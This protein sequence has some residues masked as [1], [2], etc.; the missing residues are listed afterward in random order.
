MIFSVFFKENNFHAKEKR[1]VLRYFVLS[2][3]KKMNLSVCFFCKCVH[4]IRPFDIRIYS[5]NLIIAVEANNKMLTFSLMMCCR[6]CL[7]HDLLGY[8]YK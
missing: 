2:Y 7:I 1:I 5:K 6:F 4:V 8:Y 3:F